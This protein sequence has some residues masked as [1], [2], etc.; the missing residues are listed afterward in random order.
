M[1]KALLFLI[2]SMLIS[3]IGCGKTPEPSTPDEPD[4]VDPG[5]EPEPFD[6][7]PIDQELLGCYN[8]FM[9][10][11]NFNPD[12]NG[13]GLSRDRLTNSSL[14]SIAATGFLLASYPV[15]VEQNYMTKEHAFECADKTLDT[16]LRIQA[17]EETSYGGC[18]SHFV[19]LSTGKRSSG[20][21]ISTIDTA[22]LVSGAITAGEYFKGT[23]QTKAN[24]LWSNV[25]YN[26][27]KTTKNG[28]SYISM[29]VKAPN[30]IEQL[31]A[32]DYYAEQLMIYILGAGNPNENHRITSLFYKNFTKNVGSYGG[33]S[34]IYS[35]FGSI[36]TYQYS[37]AFFNFK[38][39][40]DDKGR[41]WFENSVN[42]SKTARQFCI[43]KKD[44]YKT[45]SENSWGLTACDVPT[46][47]S[48]LLGAS[49]R[50]YQDNSVEYTGLAGTI[51]PTGAIGSM[52][53]TPEESYEALKYFQS[54]SGLNDSAFGLRD[55]FNLD[56]YGNEWYCADIIGIDKG[57]EV[58]QLYNFKNTDFVCD[59]A[60]NNPYVIQGF[61]N[62]GFAEVQ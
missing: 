45:Y 49:P 59:L 5:P 38:K 9:H 34:H 53:F 11:S 28:K 22:I 42:A 61:T 20:S 46:G 37:Q 47:Y 36:F 40:N 21:E 58:L 2:P 31:G 23:V 35:W 32:W 3:L 18:I 55:S 26:Q 39:Y 54:L 4:P 48:G 14:A 56:F 15:F 17:D 41:N 6:Y 19:N 33:I 29:G 25:D 62:N 16:V 51:A 1:K 13:F 30:Q 50:G 57:I 7:T 52:P 12:S 24:T 44:T 60:M 10:A 8:Y 27:F 43:D